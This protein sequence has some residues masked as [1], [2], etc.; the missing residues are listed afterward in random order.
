MVQ[1]FAFSACGARTLAL[2]VTCPLGV[3]G[4]SHVITIVDE[5]SGRTCTLRGAL[6]ISGETEQKTNPLSVSIEHNQ[7]R[8]E[9]TT[10]L[11]AHKRKHAHTNANC[12]N[13]NL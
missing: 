10:C 11:F 3:S 13:E 5:L 6:S 7:H 8:S 1:I 4:G 12:S 2:T 9:S